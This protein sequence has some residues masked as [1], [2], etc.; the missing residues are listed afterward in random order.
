MG[1]LHARVLS[2]MNLLGG[3]IE[4]S[5]EL[6]ANAKK[7]YNC[8]VF[9]TLDLAIKDKHIQSIIIAVPTQF[10]NSVV[11]EVIEKIPDIK[12]LLI[13]KP[14]VASIEEY[15]ENKEMWKSIS[16][17]CIVGHIEVYNPVVSKFIDIVESGEYGNIRSI[18][19]QRKSAV[20]QSRLDSLAGVVEDVG[21]HDLDILNRIMPNIKTIYAI[22]K[23]FNGKLN[24]VH[25]LIDAE[26]T[27]ATLQFSREYSGRRRTFTLEMEKATIFIDLVAQTIE[28]R[29]LGEVIGESD[30]VRVPHGPGSSIKVY[31]EPLQTE[32]N[33]LRAIAESNEIPKV[34]VM[35]GIKALKLADAIIKSVETAKIITIE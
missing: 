20:Q 26:N 3:I 24:S 6:R 5:D 30:M 21:I 22:G 19:I 32:I 7:L 11:K 9:K 12:S 29:G 17:K 34:G 18:S 35:N 4:I 23:K 1:R 10:H 13:E 25:V 33:N 15:N 27:Q 31:G 14:M 16:N 2:K 8:D 28:I